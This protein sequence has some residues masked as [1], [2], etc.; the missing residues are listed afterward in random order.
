MF[1]TC[2]SLKSKKRHRLFSEFRRHL[3]CSIGRDGIRF[4]IRPSNRL[5]RPS[6]QHGAPHQAQ[7]SQRRPPRGPSDRE[8]VAAAAGRGGVGVVDAEVGAGE[9]FDEIDLAAHHVEERHAVDHHHR[10]VAL[11]RDVAVLVGSVEVE[12]VLETGA[13]A[14]DTVIRS[15]WPSSPRRPGFR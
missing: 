1:I 2:C 4:S 9:V 6:F 13:A 8:G 7:A 14:A 15:F 10:A 12:A 3:S 11:D 5:D